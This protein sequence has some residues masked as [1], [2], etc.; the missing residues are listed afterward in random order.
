VWFR[1]E[2]IAENL[3]IFDFE[4]TADELASIDALNRGPQRPETR[5]ST[6]R[7]TA[8]RSRRRDLG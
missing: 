5:T 8:G 4:L 1:P 2:R 7:T 3:D 6:S